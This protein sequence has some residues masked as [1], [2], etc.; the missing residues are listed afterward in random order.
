SLDYAS[1]QTSSDVV[2]SAMPP[3]G[4]APPKP[5]AERD[6]SMAKYARDSFLDGEEGV[7]ALRVLVRKDGSVGDAQVVISSGAP[8]LDK[9]A[10]DAAKDWRYEPGRVDGAA[11]DT[12]VSVNI[13]WALQTLRFDMS[14]EQVMNMAT[15][16]P[17]V[18]LAR[19]E[20][21]AV[22]VRFFV[23]A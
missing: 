13:I 7:V 11:V 16:Y 1:A 3:A 22:S 9:Y 20:G 14:P 10:Q 2:D 8:R 12:W 4:Y 21:G 23:A 15:Y 5:A 6:L 18:S 17:R 19:H